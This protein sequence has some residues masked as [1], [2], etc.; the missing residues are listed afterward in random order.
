MLNL[1]KVSEHVLD[2]LRDTLVFRFH[3][4]LFVDVSVFLSEFFLER[5]DVIFECDS[6][7]VGFGF[8]FDEGVD[9]VC[10]GFDGFVGAGFVLDIELGDE[11]FDDTKDAFVAFVKITDLFE[12]FEV[13]VKFL[14]FF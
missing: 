3:K 12:D 7:L 2:E 13:G 10:E 1:L 14:F 6:G 11:S 4:F 8:F 9:L 5:L